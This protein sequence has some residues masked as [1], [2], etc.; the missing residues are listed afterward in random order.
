MAFPAVTASEILRSQ[1]FVGIELIGFLRCISLPLIGSGLMWIGVDFV[2]RTFPDFSGT[3]AG[4][5]TLVATG[6]AAYVAFTLA[7]NRK[8]LKESLELARL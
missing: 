3:I 7:V 6:V 8:D 5:V 1:R 2:S 4:L